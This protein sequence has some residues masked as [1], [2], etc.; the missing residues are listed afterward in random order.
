MRAGNREIRCAERLD[1][2]AR[3]PC[4]NPPISPYIGV[5]GKVSSPYLNRTYR[6]VAYDGARG[7]S[8]ERYTVPK[9]CRDG[10]EASGEGD[11]VEI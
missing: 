8:M 5:P 6:N 2:L 4:P 7:T 11:G 10:P 3:M 9:H 1:S